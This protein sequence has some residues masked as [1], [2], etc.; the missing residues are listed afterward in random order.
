MSRNWIEFG[1][2]PKKASPDEIGVSLNLRG[3]IV[4]NRH[5]YNEMNR[6]EAVVLLFDPDTDSIGLRPASPHALN[7]F[8]PKIKGHAQHRVVRAMAFTRK[9]N[10][11]VD[12]TV[13]F[14]TATIEDGILVLNLRYMVTVTGTPR[15]GKR[16]RQ[17]N[18]RKRWY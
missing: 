7:A 1:E 9:H 18:V 4:F 16:Q 15:K 3:E 2:G 8:R 11:K 6:P 17:A 14:P 5:T 13:R 12:G 10:I